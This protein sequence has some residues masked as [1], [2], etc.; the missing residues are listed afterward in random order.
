[1]EATPEDQHSQHAQK[2][3]F[4]AY[5]S[6][7]DRMHPPR[8][9][10]PSCIVPPTEQLV[11]RPHIVPLLPTFHGMENENPYAHI[12]EFEEVCNIF[13]EGGASIDLMRLKLF[14]F[15][16]KDKAKL[17][18]MRNSMSV[19]RYMESINACPHHGFDTW[20]LVSYFYDDMSSSMKQLLEMI[21]GGDFMSW[22]V[23]LN[24]DIDMKAKVA[25]MT[26][27]LEK[28]KG[29]V[30]FLKHQCKLC[31]VPFV[32]LLSTWWRSVLR[33]QLNHPN[34][35]WKPRAPQY[36]QLGQAPP[37][38]SNLE[39]AIVNLSKVV[40]DF[41]GDQKSIDA[42]LSQ[43]IDSV[44]STL[45]KMMDGMQND[46]SQKIDNL[47]YSISRLTNLNIVQE[48]ESFFLNL[49]K[50]PRVSMK[51]RLRRENLHRKVKNEEIKG[52]RK[53]NSANK[54]DLESTVNE[55]PEG[56]STRMI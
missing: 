1:M 25:A 41:V 34:F 16:L 32:N 50:I 36:T 49:I 3:N 7:R 18:R 48:K 51:W 10:A 30:P 26:R 14:P 47:Q 45:N 37:Q 22:D 23:Y 12:K 42:Q 6:M 54:E 24:E 15:T 21:C 29:S 39:Q 33:F 27:R 13:Q 43:R 11:I 8:M 55:E 44:E 53:G 46:Q 2:E 9:S 38:A 56:P 5:R 4:N 20:L 35:S 17:K 19:G 31:C 28:L 52:K 40:G